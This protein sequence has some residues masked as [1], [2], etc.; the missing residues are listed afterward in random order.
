VKYPLKALLDHRARQVDD[1]AA[2][3][4]AAVRTREVAAE[5]RVRAERAKREAE[6]AVAREK[7]DV[8]AR[9]AR[10]EIRAVD[11][12][13]AHGWAI[14][15][16]AEQAA[17]GA[18]LDRAASNESAAARSEEAAREGLARSMADRDDVTKHHARFEERGR[19][20]A[21]LAEEEAAE[22]AFA[23]GRR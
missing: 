17:L 10:G 7:R 18:S 22:D 23:G 15:A 1:A 19:K 13:H 20:E 12:A 8:D 14:A 11:L 3:V 2:A 9:L 4:A 21:L 5:A 6:E 16:D